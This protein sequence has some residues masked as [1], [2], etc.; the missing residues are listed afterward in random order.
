M[1][2]TCTRLETGS[3]G[4][5]A[6]K[7]HR[8]LFFTAAIRFDQQPSTLGAS[9]TMKHTWGDH[10]LR[11]TAATVIFHLPRPAKNSPSRCI[12]GSLAVQWDGMVMTRPDRDH[13]RAPSQ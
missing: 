2:E 8:S 13:M 7:S 4:T 12:R 6:A 1:R 10:R 5:V 11:A 9:K 3:Y